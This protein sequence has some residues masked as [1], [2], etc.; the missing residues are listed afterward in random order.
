MK[1]SRRK[2]SP[3]FKAKVALEALKE[4][5][6]TAEIASRFEVH[7]AQ[8]RTWKRSLMEGATDIFG[9]VQGRQKDDESLI[10][11]LYQQIGQLRVE[12][13][14]LDSRLGSLSVERR[15]AMV[16]RQRPS[17]SVGATV[18]GAGNQPVIAVLPACG[19]LTG[20]SGADEAVRQ[21]YLERPFFGSRRMAIWLR[22]QGYRINR[23]RVG[24][25]MGEMGLRAIY[26]R[27]RTSKPGL[28]LQ[29]LPVLAAKYENHQ[30]QP[31]VGGRYNLRAHGQR[32][33]VPGSHHGL[34]QSVRARL[35]S[36]QYT[37]RRLLCQGSGGGS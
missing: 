6:S 11:Q 23:K 35:A 7:P 16:E 8:V 27:P 17:L 20:G 28:G 14:F 13:D 3:A 34:A 15:R 10:A 31:G 24:R 32:F 29:G 25:L 12:R 9:G 18:Q 21:A 36:F 2:H 30:A 37:G 1:E 22:G 4:E 19:H 33:H 26:R 5:E